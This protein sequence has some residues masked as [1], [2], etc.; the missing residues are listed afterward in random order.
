MQA[1][2]ISNHKRRKSQIP[3]KEKYDTS[4]RKLNPQR[5]KMVLK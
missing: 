2:E 1:Y 4:V 3:K 5:L